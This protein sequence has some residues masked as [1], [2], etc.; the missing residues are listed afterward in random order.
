M[1]HLST[2]FSFSWGPCR[3]EARVTWTNL[4]YS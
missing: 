3:Q 4:I 2:I 1:M